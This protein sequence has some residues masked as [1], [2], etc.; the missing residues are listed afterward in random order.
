MSG[1]GLEV[2][3]EIKL[4]GI[5]RDAAADTGVLRQRRRGRKQYEPE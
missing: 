1:D 4:I 3:A 2:A 5:D